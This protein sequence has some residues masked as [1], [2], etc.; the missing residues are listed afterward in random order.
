MIKRELAGRQY[1][2]AV[3]A[4]IAVAK[5]DIFPGQ[6]AGLVWDT[7]ILEQAD[8]RWNSKGKSSCMQIVAVLFLRHGNA[9]Q[10]QHN[11]PPRGAH[12]DWL[13]RSV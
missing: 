9:L 5:Q 13:V 6:R 10:H 11:S 4:G 7:A 12:I 8:H 1:L 2:A 3:L